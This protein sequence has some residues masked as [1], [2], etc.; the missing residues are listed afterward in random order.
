MPARACRHSPYGCIRRKLTFFTAAF[1]AGLGWLGVL[2]AVNTVASLFYYLR[3]IVPALGG[4][5]D[6]SETPGRPQRT[7]VCAL[8]AVSVLLGVLSGPILDVFG[9]PLA[10]R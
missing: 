3:W 10:A 2:A 4:G 8:A 7:A 9:G 5:P 6:I 1:D